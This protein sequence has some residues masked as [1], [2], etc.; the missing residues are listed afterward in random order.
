MDF[1]LEYTKEQE[2]FA[3]GVRQWIEENVPEGWMRVRDPDK[4]SSEQWQKRRE[5]GRKLGE[6][7]WLVPG[8]PREYGG[9]GLDADHQFV[10]SQEFAEAKVGFPPHYDSGLTLAANA[11]MVCG[12]EEQKERFLPLICKGEV[13]SW[14]LF[15]EPEAGTDEANQQANALR[16]V[17]EN[18]YFVVNGSKI[19]VGSTYLPP[20]RFLLLT[21]SDL[22]AARHQ[23]LAM[24]FAP[25]DLPG[26][27]IQPLDLFTVGE[28]GMISG[29]ITDGS[30]GHKNQ[31][32]F[33]DVRLHESY[34]IGEDH[35]GWRGAT[36]TLDVEHGGGGVVRVPR[37]NMMMETFLS[38]CKSN[39]IVVK[40]LKE[41]PHLLDYVVDTYIGAQIQRLWAMRNAWLAITGKRAPGV[42]NQLQIYSKYFAARFA[43]NMAKVLGPCAFT[44][45]EEY[46]LGEG[47]DKGM[48]EIGERGALLL[49]PGGTPEAAKILLSRAL[50]IGR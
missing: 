2:E 10:L 39:P 26:I 1:R 5:L 12:T 31:V 50:R 35:E 42:G 25:A 27:T 8:L 18:D 17:R 28:F 46:S 41:N 47:D 29:P 40:R 44:S 48:F 23:N 43:A 16:H 13:V 20:D 15:T 14:E 37:A 21:R 22:E 6:K 32:F 34:L 7:G 3:R 24:F 9:G 49:A 11:I 33:D 45:D 19:F 30:H 38:Y 4:Q 36:A